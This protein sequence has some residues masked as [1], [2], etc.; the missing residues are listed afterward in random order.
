MAAG[1]TL[2][3]SEGLDTRAL[4]LAALIVTDSHC[5]IKTIIRT[6]PHN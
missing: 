4:G 2:P 1:H 6:P 3:A 5:V